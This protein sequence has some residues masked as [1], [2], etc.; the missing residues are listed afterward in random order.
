MS[1]F[2]F[3]SRSLNL[4]KDNYKFEILLENIET[5]ETL[6]IAIYSEIDEVGK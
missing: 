5:L 2:T 3:S 1:A 6:K 4:K